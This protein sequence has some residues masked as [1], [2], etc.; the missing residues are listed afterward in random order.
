LLPNDVIHDTPDAFLGTGLKPN[1]GVTDV[2]FRTALWIVK[3]LNAGVDVATD[4]TAQSM[5][6]STTSTGS[7]TR[8]TIKLSNNRRWHRFRGCCELIADKVEADCFRLGEESLRVIDHMNAIG[9]PSPAVRHPDRRY[10]S[11]RRS[12]RE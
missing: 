4:N 2:S 10:H 8:G 6:C 3:V 11:G 9:A 1:A 7:V 12:H 5:V